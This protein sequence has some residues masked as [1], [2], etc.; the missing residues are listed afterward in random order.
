MLHERVVGHGL[1]LSYSADLLCLVVDHVSLRVIRG[2]RAVRI[3]LPRKLLALDLIATA[4]RVRD[5]ADRDARAVT[6]RAV[7]RRAGPLLL[8]APTRVRP[9][10]RRAGPYGVRR[11]PATAYGVCS[12]VLWAHGCEGRAGKLTW[13]GVEHTEVRQIPGLRKRDWVWLPCDAWLEQTWATRRWQDFKPYTRR[14][15]VHAV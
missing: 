3:R 8:W 11:V 7:N 6:R 15:G 10:R 4:A 1:W 5:L 12:A 14:M 13:R 2:P 9:S